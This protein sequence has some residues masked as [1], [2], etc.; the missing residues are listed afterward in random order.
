VDDKDV[1]R[2]T[3]LVNDL[4]SDP[5][6]ATGHRKYSRRV[7]LGDAATIASGLQDEVDAGVSARAASMASQGMVVA[8]KRGCAGCCEEPIMIFRPEAVHVARWLEQPENAA[9]REAFLAAYPDW[10]QR[11]GDTPARLSALFAGQPGPYVEAHIEAWNLGVPCAF[12]HGGDCTIYP[13]RPINCRTAHALNTSE[14]CSGAATQPAARASFVPLDQ[15]IARTRK[16]LQAT[17]NA[18]GG[19]R[20]RVEALCVTVYEL[21]NRRR[22]R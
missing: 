17:H 2:L 4:A 10:K 13:V 3:K 12:N 14:Y 15:F 22:P 7:S 9:V 8:C 16:L 11:V 19:P 21:L 6:Y 5:A 18:I 1:T 20:A